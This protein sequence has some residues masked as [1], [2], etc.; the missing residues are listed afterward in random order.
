MLLRSNRRARI[1]SP[2]FRVVAID[3]QAVLTKGV[4][5]GGVRFTRLHAWMT[6]PVSGIFRRA[7]RYPCI[8]KF[9]TMRASTSPGTG[10]SGVPVI[11]A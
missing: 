11:S 8:C 7:Q 3:G 9:F 2:E 10:V 6:Q 1:Q 4:G 5:N